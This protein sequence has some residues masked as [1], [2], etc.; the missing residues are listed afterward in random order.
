M[1]VM[2][3]RAKLGADYPDL[4]IRMAGLN[5]ATDRSVSAFGFHLRRKITITIPKVTRSRSIIIFIL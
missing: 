2:E 5:F 3:A 1:Q 4:L